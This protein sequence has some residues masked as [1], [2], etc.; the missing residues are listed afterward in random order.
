MLSQ[1]GIQCS[2]DFLIIFWFKCACVILYICMYVCMY[3]C[4][5]V[6][7]SVNVCMYVTVHTIVIMNK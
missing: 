2:V 7:M 3:A 5:Y 1:V 4:M 6:C